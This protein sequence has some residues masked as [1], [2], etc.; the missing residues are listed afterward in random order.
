MAQ[1]DSDDV[2]IS[3]GAISGVDIDMS[4][5]TLTLDDDQI[6]IDKIGTTEL[7]TGKVLIPDGA[8][9]VEWGSSAANFDKIVTENDSTIVVDNSGNVV[10]AA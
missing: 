3:G 2:N 8:G 1:Q 10:V 9:G 5:Q 4:G 6:D 7:D